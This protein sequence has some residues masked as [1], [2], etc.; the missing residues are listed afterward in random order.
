M[1]R[2]MCQAARLASGQAQLCKGLRLAQPEPLQ[3]AAIGP[4][5][6]SGAFEAAVQG[7]HI[8]LLARQPGVDVYQCRGR[9]LGGGRQEASGGNCVGVAANEEG[10]A[11]LHS[12][13]DVCTAGSHAQ[14]PVEDD[15]SQD[16]AARCCER[17][18]DQAGARHNVLAKHFVIADK[19]HAGVP[20]AVETVVACVVE[21]R[22]RGPDQFGL[23]CR[24]QGVAVSLEA[25]GRQCDARRAQGTE[26][27]RG[28]RDGRRR[29]GKGTAQQ[30]YKRC[31]GRGA[32]HHPVLVVVAPGQQAPAH[33]IQRHIGRAFEPVRQRL[34]VAVQRDTCLGG[35]RK[36]PRL[37]ARRER[38]RRTC[39]LGDDEVRIRA[40][41]AKRA[42]GSTTGP[43]AR[44][45]R[46]GFQRGVDAKRRRRKADGCV[47]M[48]EVQR[49]GQLLGLERL[50]DLDDTS[51]ATGTHRVA[52]VCF[53]RADRAEAARGRVGTEGRAERLDLD[54]IA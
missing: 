53:G 54:R 38:T 40:A 33:R 39:S 36:G 21:Q 22:M 2:V 14:R 30:T 13:L 29:V 18:L 7:R 26:Q 48:F 34:A 23:G 43:A 37:A 28:H 11:G 15:V 10:R 1:Q 49:G 47:F 51:H 5:H 25:I 20:M 27:L 50:E 45:R 3:A 17:Q 41:E 8:H 42:H 46:P 52:D 9:R 35:H 24:A 16:S 4:E 12:Q 32:Q 19:W 44:G 31:A 6:H